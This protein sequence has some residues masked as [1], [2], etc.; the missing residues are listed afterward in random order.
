MIASTSCKSINIRNTN[1]SSRTLMSTWILCLFLFFWTSGNVVDAKYGFFRGGGVQ[2]TSRKLKEK[3]KMGWGKEKDAD[4]GKD[5][6]KRIDG[7]GG[8]KGGKKEGKKEADAPMAE[9]SASTP[10]GRPPLRPNVEQD[11]DLLEKPLL[12]HRPFVTAEMEV[13]AADEAK[14]ED[15]VDPD[16]EGS[17]I[18]NEVEEEQ[19]SQVDDV[20]AA[21]V[22][23]NSAEGVCDPNPCIM[24]DCATISSPEGEDEAVCSC[25]PGY[26]G[27]FCGVIDPC[28][29]L[30]CEN[31]S[32]CNSLGRSDGQY[33]CFCLSGFVGENCQY[34]D[35]CIPTDPCMNGGTCV[36]LLETIVNGIPQVN[37]SCAD[38]FEGTYC[39]IVVGQ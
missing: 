8:K 11:P 4:F 23:Y 33:T 16:E 39:G 37:C 18:E 3:R 34:E 30:P 20:Q 17:D 38:G 25:H 24:G 6:E 5:E 19:E 10:T 32:T 35:P 28:L 9:Q 7:M 29:D 22:V 2:A 13:A 14:D 21:N 27:E 36:A 1:G 15:E 26:V 31:G 12:D